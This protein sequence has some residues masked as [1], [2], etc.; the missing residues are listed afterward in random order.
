MNLGDPI[1]RLRDLARETCNR[2]SHRGAKVS[3]RSLPVGKTLFEA[4]RPTAVDTTGDKGV[5]YSPVHFKAAEDRPVPTS[6]SGEYSAAS[7]PTSPGGISVP[8]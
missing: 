3:S 6:D 7:S 5:R 4:R 8:P 1:S 2:V